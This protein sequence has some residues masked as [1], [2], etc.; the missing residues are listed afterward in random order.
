[1]AMI[2]ANSTGQPS[3]KEGKSYGSTKGNSRIK[4]VNITQGQA[5]LTDEDGWVV[6]PERITNRKRSIIRVVPI[7]AITSRAGMNDGQYPSKPSMT[8]LI[9]GLCM[10]PAVNGAPIIMSDSSV[11]RMNTHLLDITLAMPVPR[12]N[13]PFVSPW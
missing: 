11:S 9:S 2:I 8:G 10:A 3:T 7:V 13:A 1:M 6:W 4:I 12:N 5:I